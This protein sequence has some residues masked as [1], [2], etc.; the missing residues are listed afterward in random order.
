MFVKVFT[1]RF[2]LLSVVIL[3]C[4]TRGLG[5]TSYTFIFLNKN[6]EA[7]TIT[8]EESQKIMEGHMAN[9]NKLAQEGKL[10][11]AGPFEGGGGIF[12]FRKASQEELTE[13]LSADPG[14]QAKRWNIEQHLYTPRHNG[15]CVVGE[16]YQMVSYSF[17]RFDA[18][19][20]KSNAG[21]F[22]QIIK[23]HDDYLKDIIAKG[24][25]ITEG[26]FGDHAGGIMVLKGDVDKSVF[27][28][29]PGVQEGLISLTLKKL[30]IAKGAFCEKD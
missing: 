12:V 3:I 7:P 22:P 19:V 25:V 8:K 10:L 5:Q 14:I 30:Y 2:I 9:I 11:A 27:E 24:N 6:Q 26:I 13:W 18:V 29:D 28:S 17:V 1:M 4:G 16:P 20:S 23:S 15:I 21:T